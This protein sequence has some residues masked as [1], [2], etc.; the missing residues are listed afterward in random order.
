MSLKPIYSLLNIDNKLTKK[1]IRTKEYNSFSDNYRRE[2][3]CNFMLDLLFLP[4]AKY[5]MKFLLVC[6]DIA[7]RKFDIEPIKDKTSTIV[8]KAFKKMIKRQYISLP[9]Y[10]VITD[11]G[12]EFKG[13]FQDFMYDES[14]FHKTTVRGRHKQLALIDNLIGQLSKIFNDYM[15]MKEVETGKVYKNWTEIIPIVR[16][17]LNKIREVKLPSKNEFDDRFV[18]DIR[19]VK[20]VIY[21]KKT[22]DKIETIEKE[23]IR[24]KYKVGQLVYVLLDHPKN[25]L[26]KNQSSGQF[27]MGDV[28]ITSERHEITEIVYM[29]GN[30]GPV[31][32]YIVD[33]FRHVSFTESELRTRL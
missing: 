1:R 5:G 16:L 15:N 30:K 33:G 31:H 22:G 11:G 10:S 20:K 26:G 13:L 24:P 25:A 23:F 9:K 29:N 12:S 6:L 8:L 3:N 4:T 32:R 7:T 27:R 19:E 2:A 14:I 21:N 28:R 17:E 18:N